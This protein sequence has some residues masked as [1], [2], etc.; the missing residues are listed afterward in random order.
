MNATE[1][2][3]SACIHCEQHSL[4]VEIA[5]GLIARNKCA[6][7]ERKMNVNNRQ[8]E[9]KEKVRSPYAECCAQASMETA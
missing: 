6:E 1:I 4:F 9:N 5:L 3:D 8:E 2:D 7:P